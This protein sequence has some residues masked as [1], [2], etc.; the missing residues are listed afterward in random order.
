MKLFYTID[1][2]PKMKILEDN[3]EI[4]KNEIPEFIFENSEIEKA[5][6]YFIDW[7]DMIE[8]KS[9]NNKYLRVQIENMPNDEFF[10]F[11]EVEKTTDYF[12]NKRINSWKRRKYNLRFD[13]IPEGKTKKD[14]YEMYLRYGY[15]P[16]KVLQ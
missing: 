4:I 3:Y 9:C 7:N 5:C 13:D 10:K 11:I 15:R 16:N 12:K 6:R 8:K 14:F 1:D 2:Y